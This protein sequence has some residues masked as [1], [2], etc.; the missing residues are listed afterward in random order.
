MATCCY[1]GALYGNGKYG[2]D[3]TVNFEQGDRVGVL[4]DLDGGS[5]WSLFASTRI[6]ARRHAA[7]S[8]GRANS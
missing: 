7:R 4:L 1:Y 3:E 2:D 6:L 8:T 5:L